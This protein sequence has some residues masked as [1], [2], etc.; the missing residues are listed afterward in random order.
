MEKF[1]FVKAEALSNDF[2]II[3]DRPDGSVVLSPTEVIS[4]CDRRRGIGAD[5]VLLL[6]PSETCDFRMRTLNSDGSEAEM[7]GNGI[8][9][10]VKFVHDTGDGRQK[11]YTVET[12]AGTISVAL[13][14]NKDGL[15]GAIKVDLGQPVIEEISAKIDVV[16]HS[17][18]FTSVSMG[19]PHAIVFVDNVASAP[20]EHLGPAIEAHDYFPDKTNVEFIKVVGDNVIEM[21]VWER[22][23]GETAACGTG[24]AAALAAAHAKGKI[25]RSATLKLTGG[26]LG[27]ELDKNGHIF[28][29]GGANLVYS[30]EYGKE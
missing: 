11:S 4:I 22:G 9:C 6:Q 29:T 26:D 21:R 14:G 12:L 2:V 7:C 17:I 8:R 3:D 5:G 10:A 28:I 19:N 24:A 18:A 23:A 25:G 20:I 27:V 13:T 15:A 30:G 16:G 1:S